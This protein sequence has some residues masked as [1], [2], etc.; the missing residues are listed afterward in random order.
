MI[1]EKNVL[2]DFSEFDDVYLLKFLRARKFIL[3]KTF[4]MFEHFII[5]RKENKVEGLINYKFDQ[6]KEIKSIYPHAYHKTDKYV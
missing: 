6:L 3:Q 2:H 4:E 5:W 1:L